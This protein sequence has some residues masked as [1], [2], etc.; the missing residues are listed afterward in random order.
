MF[1][2]EIGRSHWLAPW[3]KGEVC[4]ALV[5]YQLLKW[6]ND[7]MLPLKSGGRTDVYIN[8]R[9]ARNRAKAIAYI[10]RLYANSLRRLPISRFVEV[11]DSVSCFAGPI[12]INTGMPYITIREQ[13]KEGR[14]AKA[15]V[16][17]SANPGE[18]VAILDDVI[19]DGESKI[20]PYFECQAMYLYSILV[21]LVDRQQGWKKNFIAK[22]VA[23]DV[24]AGMTLHDVRRYLIESGRMER[25]K[26]EKEEKNP[27]IVALDGKDWEDI[28]P[29]I[30]QLRTTG[31]IFK[32]NDLLLNEGIRNLLPDLQIYGRVMADLKGHDIKNT[33]ENISKRLLKNPP[34]AV[35][36]HGSGGEEMIQSV[37]KKFE[38]TSTKVLVVTVLTSIDAKTCKEIY[39]CLPIQEVRKLAKIAKNAG[40]HG[41]VCST[42]ELQEMKQKY[43]D[44]LKVVPGIR[45]EGVDAGDQK[46]VGTPKGAKEAGADYL[47]MGRQIF[48]AQNPSIEALK[49]IVDELGIR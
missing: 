8:L 26:R 13:I 33:L 29:V 14:V 47:V 40:A 32:V 16:I 25:C 6:D 38:G 3:E 45:S 41:L 27:L 18:C 24:W 46:R 23:M 30:D 44:L 36:V 43:P 49:I 7:R 42:N 37:V 5:N 19:T 4:E 22:D 48:G 15:K 10:S 17:G 35:T 1:N 31:C 2:P 28:L 34:W 11:P 9:D 12:S 39:S 20:I 21:V